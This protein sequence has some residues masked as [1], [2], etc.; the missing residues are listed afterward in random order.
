MQCSPTTLHLVTNVV[1]EKESYDNVIICR[2][3]PVYKYAT[4]QI[5]HLVYELFFCCRLTQAGTW[6][7]DGTFSAQPS[8][9]AQLYTI[10]VKVHDEFSPQI[11]C[12]LPDKQGTTYTRLFQLLKQEALNIN[13]QLQPAVIHVDFEMAVMQTIRAEFNIEPTG[14]LFHYSQNVLRHVQ[15]AGLQVSYNTNAPP[16]VR[17]WIRRLISLPLV[18]PLRI[19]Q[20]FQAVVADAPNVINRDIMNDYVRD[21]YVDLQRAMFP[22]ATWNCFAVRDRTTNVCEGYHSALNKHFRNRSP[23][24]FQFVEFLKDQDMQLE[25]RLAQLLQ[26]APAKKRK[27]TYILLD[28]AIDRLRNVYFGAGIPNVPRL[29]QYMDAVGHQLY[30]IKQ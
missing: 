21:T 6:W 20:A 3:W 27:T 14:C 16:E 9:F 15:H 25:R 17:T 30:D 12:L 23:D 22:R 7:M 11:W 4:G 26:G 29:L 8:I 18:P 19:D 5:L 1:N 24:P 28:E 13:L 2:R 10:H